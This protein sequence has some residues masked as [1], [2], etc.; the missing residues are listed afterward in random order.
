MV[1]EEKAKKDNKKGEA[2]VAKKAKAPKAEKAE[3]VKDE[4]SEAEKAKDLEEKKRKMAEKARELAAGLKGEEKITA[5]D[6]RAA[7]EAKEGKE[8]QEK[9]E[10]EIKLE[11]SSNMLVPLDDYVKSGIYLGTKVITQD[12][13]PYVFKRRTDGLA[14]INTRIVD[15]KIREAVSFISKYE[16][17][18]IVVTCKREAGWKAIKAFGKA[19]GIKVFTKK[20]P[21][22]IITNSVLEGF[23]EPSLMVVVDPWLDKNPMADANKINVPLVG[24]CDTNNLTSSIDLVIPGNNKSGKSIGLIFWILARGYIRER[25]L[26]SKLPEL[27]EFVGE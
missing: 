8:G 19:T 20:Y 6:V 12:M 5:A 21:A 10:E 13:R 17:E 26:D 16:P 25:K 15:E 4:R 22:G 3:A 1:E 14:I 23:F 11:S 18:N 9:G 7:K 27:S 2:K 24:V